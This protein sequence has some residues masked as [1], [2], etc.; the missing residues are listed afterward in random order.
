MA[1][2]WNEIRDR[3][4]AFSRE[5]KDESS[6][7]A[8]AKTFWDEFF[9][10]FGVSRRRQA[11]FE[12]HVKKGDGHDG[13]VDLFWKGK[14]LAEHKSRGKDL[15]RAHQQAID[16][17]PGLKDEDLPRYVVVSDFARF[18]V[19][20]LD[21]GTEVEFP[22]EE[23]PNQVQ[24][25]G[26]IAG[27]EARKFREQDPVNIK[28]AEKL[29]RLHDS[30]ADIGY[31]GHQLE[32]YL[33]RILLC[34]FA[35][36]TGIFMPT[37]AF[38]D[39]IRTRTSEDGSDLAARINEMFDVLDT[40]EDKRFKNLDEQLAAFPYVNGRLFTENLRTASFDKRMRDMLLECCELDWGKISPAIFG[41]LFQIGR[42]S[43][44]ERV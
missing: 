24:V 30:L 17:F 15:S 7:H 12:W 32:V 41:S 38:E 3:A 13:Y 2:S 44:R 20:D 43:C 40:P 26:F 25:F 34:L 11:S 8:E 18:R 28:A 37:G 23:F 31:D 42:A 5:W 9:Q 16:Y 10:V 6:E 22:L 33:V 19:H 39:Y 14:M 35:E 29:G 1:L 36:D 21:E 4:L 27:Y